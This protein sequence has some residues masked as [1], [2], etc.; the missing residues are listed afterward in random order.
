M[1]LQQLP[2][3]TL[4]ELLQR[5]GS[6]LLHLYI[7]ESERVA[8]KT[9]TAVAS[10]CSAEVPSELNVILLSRMIGTLPQY[11]PLGAPEK[12]DAA[13]REANMRAGRF[14]Q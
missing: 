2:L 12:D 5:V 6:R 9:A 10:D 13:M 8:D 7:R 3:V 11:A 14:R 4:A 1:L